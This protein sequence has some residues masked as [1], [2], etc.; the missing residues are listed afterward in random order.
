MEL[1]L[2]QVQDMVGN[3]DGNLQLGEDVSTT[4]F[5]E[6]LVVPGGLN[7]SGSSVEH[8]PENLQMADA[9]NVQDADVK[10][11][12]EDLKL[13]NSAIERLPQNLKVAGKL[14][15]SCTKEIKELPENFVVHGDLCLGRNSIK[16]LPNNLKVGGVL[17]LSRMK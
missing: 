4:K 5:P 17:D 12:P 11:L 2:Q 9:S 10:V 3:N 14:D 15:L 6:G 16:K 1:T 7:L 8:L 13:S